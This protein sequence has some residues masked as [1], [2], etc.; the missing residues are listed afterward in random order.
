MKMFYCLIVLLPALTLAQEQEAESLAPPPVPPC[1]GARYHQFDF[2]IG[3]WNVTENGEPAGTNSI[4]PIMG[5]CALQE[6]WQGTGPGGMSGT[7]FNIYDQARDLWHQSWVDSTGTLLLLDGGMKN[8]AMVMQGERP[9]TDGE[10][11]TIHRISWTR[12][13]DGS[14]RQLWE[15]SPDGQSWTVLFDG[16]YTRTLPD[17]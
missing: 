3:E 6:N 11:I 7:S 16:L 10:G 14:V 1:S 12:N 13:A 15:A 9:A 17:S 8:G 5:G 4:Q 2:W